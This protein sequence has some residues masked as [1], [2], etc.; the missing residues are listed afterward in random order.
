M[1]IKIE[2]MADRFILGFTLFER[3]AIINLPYYDIWIMSEEIYN[4]LWGTE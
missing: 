2:R 4:E 3:Y 1:K